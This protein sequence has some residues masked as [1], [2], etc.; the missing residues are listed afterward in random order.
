[1]SKKKRPCPRGLFDGC[2]I[3]RE[4]CRDDFENTGSWHC[5]Q[6]LRDLEGFIFGE[7]V[8]EK[9]SEDVTP[10]EQLIRILESEV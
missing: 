2:P 6:F 4:L 10:A 9:R 5:L 1:M 3:P 7:D 8:D